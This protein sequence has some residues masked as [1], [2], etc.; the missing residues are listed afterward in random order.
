MAAAASRFEARIAVVSEAGG[1]E[2][3]RMIERE[4]IGFLDPSCLGAEA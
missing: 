1:L 4:L 3:S 2:T